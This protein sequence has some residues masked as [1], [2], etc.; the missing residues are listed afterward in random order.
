MTDSDVSSMTD[1]REDPDDV[2]S[3]IELDAPAHSLCVNV[4]HQEEGMVSVAIV[5]FAV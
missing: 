1:Y 2:L 4:S 3:E 5:D